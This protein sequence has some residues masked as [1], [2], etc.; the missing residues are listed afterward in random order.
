M[1]AAALAGGSHGGHPLGRD[2]VRPAHARL[3]PGLPPGALREGGRRGRLPLRVRTSQG[4]L[5]PQVYTG[6]RPHLRTVDPF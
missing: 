6:L 2:G 1:W 4:P 5:F 3:Q